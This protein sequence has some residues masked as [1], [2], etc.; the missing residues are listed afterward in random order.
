MPR[1]NR[2][3]WLSMVAAAL[4]AWRAAVLL[5]QTPDFADILKIDLHSHVFE[6]IPA[7]NAMLRRN[8]VRTMNVCNNGSDVKNFAAMHRIAIALF[9]AHPDLFP[10]ASTFDVTG[11]NDAD[12]SRKVIAWLDGTFRDGAVAVK[13]WKEVG[14][15]VKKKDGSFILPDDE[16]FDPIY[17]HLAKSRKPLLAHLAEPIDAWLPLDPDSVHYGYYSRNPQWHLYGKPQYPSHAAIIAARD[18]ILE[19]HP[20]LTLIG[21]HLGSLEHD[22]DAIAQRLDRYPNFHIEC[23]A[24]TRNLVRHPSEKVRALFLKYQDRIMYGVDASWKPFLAATAPTETQ[25]QDHVT[26]LEQR[27]RTDFQYFAGTGA[28][29]YD[30]RPTTS[31]G[32]PREV[33]EKFYNRNARRLIAFPK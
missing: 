6:D 21:A 26:R 9:K 28:M 13:I 24:R 31:L 30:G 1:M 33:L 22:L 12:Y 25:R 23:A 18:R 32:L 10:F 27:Y 16:V 11:V 29:Q 15:E 3:Q 17:A 5:A 8:N 14:L 19:K 2:R 20:T 7:L 4:P